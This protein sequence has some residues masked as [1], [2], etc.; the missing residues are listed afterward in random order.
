MT[1]QRCAGVAETT[2]RGEPSSQS[3]HSR[4]RTGIL[5]IF[6]A[7]SGAGKD[8]VIQALKNEGFD[9]HY[10]IT[11]T[12]RPRRP[13]EIEGVHYRFVSMAEFERLRD[14]G[15]LLEHAFVHGNWYGVPREP[16]R[17]A[18]QAG[19]DVLLKIDVQGARTVKAAVPD[20]VL[21]FLLPPSVEE[22]IERMR[23]RRTETEDELQ[24]RIESMAM[25]LN[26]L[27][28]YDYVVENPR[29]HVECAVEKVKAIIVAERCRVARRRFDI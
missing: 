27:P 11:C 24:R 4:R 22:S 16:I 15:E 10:A 13:N 2:D 3:P 17:R 6:S 19:K 28:F 18:L 9:V 12:T 20:S 25:E 26:S 23:Q 7:P 1:A 5:F 21:I 8:T 14:S 29:G